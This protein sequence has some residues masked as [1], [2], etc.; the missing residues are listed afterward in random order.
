MREQVESV[1]KYM[2]KERNWIIVIVLTCL[3][4][5]PLALWLNL[6]ALKLLLQ[7]SK[8]RS[9][10]IRFLFFNILLSIFL[11]YIGFHELSFLRSRG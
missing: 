1:I 8:F 11:F 7:T 9:W 5:A 10:R 6:N 2:E 4:L 3:I